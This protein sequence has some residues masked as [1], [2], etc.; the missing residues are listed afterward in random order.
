M[1][2]REAEQRPSLD[3]TKK[4]SPKKNDLVV[5]K[6]DSKVHVVFKSI[7]KSLKFLLMTKNVVLVPLILFL[8]NAKYFRK[9][10]SSDQ[11]GDQMFFEQPVGAGLFAYKALS[12]VFIP[13]SALKQVCA[14]TATA[15]ASASLN[16]LIASYK[17]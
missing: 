6:S 10:F 2:I 7:L 8:L 13:A 5:I 3:T 14:S 12:S 17:R 4:L 16:S 15:A 11:L 1:R 9:E